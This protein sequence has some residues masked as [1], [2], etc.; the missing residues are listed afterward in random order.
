MKKKKKWKKPQDREE[1][2]V[3]K[4]IEFVAAEKGL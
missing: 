3:C 1:G 2:V 4:V